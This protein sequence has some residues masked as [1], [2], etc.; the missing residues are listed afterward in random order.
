MTTQPWKAQQTIDPNLALEII[1]DQFPELCA[2]KIQ[3][4]GVGWDNTAYLVNDAF[5]FRFPRREIAVPLLTHELC[6]LP[7]ISDSLPLPIPKPEW[8]GTAAKGYTWPFI[9][10]RML[11]GKTAC[12]LELSD[13][14]RSSIAAPL[15]QFLRALH[16]IP[17]SVAQSCNLPK[18]TLGKLDIVRLTPL[19]K[20]SL[21]EM[22]LLGLLENKKQLLDLLDSLQ[23]VRTPLSTVIVHGDFYARHL[24][25]D[26]DRQ[27]AGVIDWGDIHVGDPAV[28]ISIAHSFLPIAAQEKFRNIYGEISEETWELAR[29]RAL[30]SSPL[31]VLYGTHSGD[32]NIANEGR[33]ALNQIADNF[34][35]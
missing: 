2:E 20:K 13:S 10:Y 11:A 23:N 22:E 19:I 21:N 7:K 34:S 26:E 17:L 27:A 33:R 9:G 18:D 3:L 32:L 35:N 8:S 31:L 14:E 25:L 30:Y 5:V 28:D 24:L 6:M 12:R 4:L 15:A 16:S 1:D 29:L